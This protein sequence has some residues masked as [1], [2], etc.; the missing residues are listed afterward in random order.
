MIPNEI[1]LLTADEAIEKG[2]HLAL[3]RKETKIEGSYE[4]T[5]EDISINQRTFIFKDKVGNLICGRF[6]E[7]AE[8]FKFVTQVKFMKNQK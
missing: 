1:E 6:K 7:P 5:S 8:L 4:I 2:L 3:D